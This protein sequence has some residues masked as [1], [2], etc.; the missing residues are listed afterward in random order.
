MIYILS[1]SLGEQRHSVTQ[2][3]VSMEAVLLKTTSN[4]HF[5]LNS[6]ISKELFQE[7]CIQHKSWEFPIYYYLNR[8][9]LL[10]FF[11]QNLN[12]YCHFSNKAMKQTCVTDIKREYQ[13]ALSGI[14]TYDKLIANA[15]ST[16]TQHVETSCEWSK[17]SIHMKKP[18]KQDSKQVHC[19][20]QDHG[21]QQLTATRKFTPETK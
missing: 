20:K 16:V 17:L 5:H 6:S 19:G 14:V 8:A 7:G 18:G 11:V 21:K 10:G 3:V 1:Y 9:V 2:S 12:H 15:D 4:K 13:N